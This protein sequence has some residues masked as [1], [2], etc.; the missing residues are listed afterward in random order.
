MGQLCIPEFCSQA[1]G[2]QFRDFEWTLELMKS[3]PHFIC[4]WGRD[5]LVKGREPTRV[6]GRLNVYEGHLKPAFYVDLD[7]GDVS[8][9]STEADLL[10]VGYTHEVHASVK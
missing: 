6:E 2:C 8:Q 10:F 9:M 3:C 1:E 4:D 5:Q 7:T